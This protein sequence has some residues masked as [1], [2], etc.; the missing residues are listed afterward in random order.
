MGLRTLKRRGTKKRVVEEGK[1]IKRLD[2][3][4]SHGLRGTRGQREG[5]TDGEV[6]KSAK[7]EMTRIVQ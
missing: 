7:N 5:T 1:K 3:I 6:S 4:E 2:N